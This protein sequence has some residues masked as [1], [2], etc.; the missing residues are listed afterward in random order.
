MREKRYID[1]FEGRNASKLVWLFFAPF[2]PQYLFLLF[3]LGSAKRTVYP[4]YW[5]TLLVVAF[6]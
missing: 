4:I 2:D 1:R 3:F 6:A 5:N